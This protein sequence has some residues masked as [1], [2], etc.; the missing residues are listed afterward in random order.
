MYD[1]LQSPINYGGIPLKNRIIFAPTTMGL[2]EEEYR[3]RLKKIAGGGCAM[4]IRGDI[5]VTV[6]GVEPSLYTEEGM[7]YYRSLVELVHGQ[8]CRISAQ[9]YLSD[10]MVETDWESRKENPEA[11]AAVLRRLPLTDLPAYIEERSGEDLEEWAECFGTAAGLAVRA[12]FDGVQVL[13][14]RMIGSISS[15]VFNHRIDEYGGCPENRVRFAVNAVR[16]I[17][18]ANPHLP[19]DYKL[20]VRQQN[21]DY[22]KAGPLVEELPVFVRALEEAGVGSFHVAPANHS[23]LRDII[24]GAS[25]PD[26]GG[27][28]PFLP[29]CDE[30][31]KYTD[32][33][34]CGVGGLTDFS[35]VEAQLASGR[36]DCA[37]MSRAFLAD[38]VWPEKL[39][40]GRE[41]E[42][43]TCIRCNGSCI[44]GMIHKSGARCFQNR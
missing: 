6:H 35:F 3:E 36:I 20:P 8:G 29:Y 31:R 15:S 21:P 25:H 23:F 4:I 17:R 44:D 26:F 2:P 18:R 33:P 11:G 9:L 1:I 41:E 5:P 34:V 43:H 27:R 13:G 32:L 37:A 30:V 19:I 40:S 28:G 22:G 12:G 38:E 14:D 10:S 24:P 42:I 39:F 7:G 16:A